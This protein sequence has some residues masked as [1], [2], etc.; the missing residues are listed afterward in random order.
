MDRLQTIPRFA[1]PYGLGDFA[2]GCGA[3]LGGRPSPQ[4]FARILGDRPRFWTGSGRQA[5]W[6]ILKALE[7]KPGAGVA[8]PLYADCSVAA[9]VR[10]AGLEPVFVDVDE[11]TLTMDPKA[12]E[13]ARNRIAAVI[14]LHFFGHVAR[15]K[16]L[17]EAA[18][19]IPV[20]EDTAHAPLSFL[21]GRMAGSFGVACFY[22]FAS[23]KYWPAG[24]GGLAVVNG[25]DLAVKV[26]TQARKLVPPGWARECRNLLLQGAKSAIFRRPLYGLAGLA[27]RPQIERHGALE[28]TLD[29]QAIQ[30]P[31]AAVALRQALGFLEL[32]EK[33]RKNS[34][35]LLSLLSHAEGIV[36]PR[37][38]PG[39][40]Y[41]YHLFP[42]LLAGAEERAAVARGMLER[43]VDTSRIY[44]DIIER[45]RKLGY[46]AGCPVSES[47]VPRMLTL[48]NYASLSD[49]DVRRVAEAFLAALHEH[50]S[51][52]RSTEA[53]GAAVQELRR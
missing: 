37:E 39:A 52:K 10:D 15:I 50:R 29:G 46:S 44:F 17:I 49:R 48:P 28:P 5:L 27:V 26:E 42:V 11:Q 35:R 7:L 4:G 13:Q 9:T 20:I 41:N 21:N 53:A 32:V 34:L 38:W 14:V 22:S 19:G 18:D 12:L 1:I 51:C 3:L 2:S 43:G 31:Q 16:E 6:L 40:R 36:L 25:R 8:T 33:Q 24:G 47:A 23:T 30:R 45:S